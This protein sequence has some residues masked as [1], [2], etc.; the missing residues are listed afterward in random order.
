MA[1]ERFPPY[2]DNLVKAYADGLSCKEAGRSVGIGVSQAHYWLKKYGIDTSQVARSFA[3]ARAG[4]D[5]IRDRIV[6]AFKDGGSVKAVAERFGVQRSTV[7][8]CLED[9]G[10]APRSRS[11]AMILRMASTTDDD[12]KALAAAANKARRGA[13][14]SADELRKKAFTKARTHSKVGAAEYEFAD[15]LTS[16]GM[17]ADLQYPVG[18]YNIDIMCWPIAVEIHSQAGHPHSDARCLQRIKY[19]CDRGLSVVYIKCAS[20][21]NDVW[22]INAPEIICAYH[23]AALHEATQTDPSL[24]GQYWV[25]R[26]SGE[27]ITSSCCDLDKIALVPVPGGSDDV[28]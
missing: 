10:I 3:K 24:L 27:T 21:R 19:L 22:T 17:H 2:I 13:Q 1:G 11:K 6:Q 23:I 8:R 20:W 16:I 28:S 12:K 25:V 7:I 26:R 15:T 5:E 4:R 9:V 14:A 18:P